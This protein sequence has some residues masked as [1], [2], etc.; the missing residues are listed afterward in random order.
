MP[1]AIAAACRAAF[2]A[3]ARV[4]VLTGAGMSAESGVPTF[5]GGGDSLWSRFDPRVLA[6][7]DAW[8]RDPALVWA[9]YRWRMHLVGQARPHA[10]HFALAELGRCH[11]QALSLVTQNVDDLHERAGSEVQAHVHGSLFALRCFD[12]GQAY[13]RPLPD[14]EPGLERIAPP[15]CVA[16]G[17]GVR[18]GVVW[19]GEALPE[20]AWRI[21][22]GCAT[23]CA[24]MLVVGTSGLVH[25]AAGLPALARRN[26]AMVVEINPEPTALSD[27]VDHA[28]RANAADAL[29]R[30]LALHPA[31]PR[32]GAAD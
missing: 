19:F 4:C 9:W 31:A 18:P 2:A 16:C 7:A 30:L 20:A 22:V 32:A 10:G 5:R 27:T 21:A 28:W 11:G 1:A 14:Y 23:G 29:P 13:D 15:A 6:T 3:A 25:P 12:C 8:R 26:G 24:L 17:G